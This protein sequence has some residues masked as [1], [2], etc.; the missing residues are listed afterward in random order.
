M[1]KS[2]T[3]KQVMNNGDEY[4]NNLQKFIIS[5]KKQNVALKKVINEIENKNNK[6]R[7]K[8]PERAQDLIDSL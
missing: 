5:K 8:K 3:E 6:S 1:L 2:K 7:Q 4:V